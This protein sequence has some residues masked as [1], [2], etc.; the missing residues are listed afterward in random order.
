MI[1]VSFAAHPSAIFSWH[2]AI[3]CESA[4]ILASLP[5]ST[6]YRI[7]DFYRVF[8]IVT[9][10][11]MNIIIHLKRQNF[12]VIEKAEILPHKYRC[13]KVEEWGLKKFVVF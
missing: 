3:I 10:L 9:I 8:H 13:H 4:C 11:L 5:K 2:C 12:L 7:E 1:F 6:C